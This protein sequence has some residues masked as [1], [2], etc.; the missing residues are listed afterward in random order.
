MKK[1][2]GL[3]GMLFACSFGL[4]MFSSCGDEQFTFSSYRNN[5]TIDNSL[6]QDA[7]LASAMNPNA[8]GIF[9]RISFSLVSGAKKFVFENNHGVKTDK[10]FTAI[11]ERLQSEHHIGMNNGLIVGFGIYGSTFFAYD[12]QCPNCFDYNV[13]PLRNYP[14]TMQSTGIAA[15]SNCKREYDLN[16]EGNGLTRYR[17]YTTGPFGTLHVD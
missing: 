1:R 2:I 11:D 12:N 8:K 13:L 7:T 5:L 3:L 16:V 14:L 6:H 9:C 4:A 15:C 17:A 10:N